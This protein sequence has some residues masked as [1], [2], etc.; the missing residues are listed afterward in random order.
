MCAWP[1]AESGAEWSILVHHVV[2]LGTGFGSMAY[3]GEIFPATMLVN[4]VRR[5]MARVRPAT[6]P[7]TLFPPPP[8]SYTLTRLQA[9]TPFVHFHQL[10]LTQG[11]KSGPLVA[12]NGLL[13]W[14]GRM[15]WFVSGWRPR[16]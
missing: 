16:A 6:M 12:V 11:I 9:S 15:T 1:V 5:R 13:L 7:V 14:C 10:L 3:G 4:E 2:V 8:Q